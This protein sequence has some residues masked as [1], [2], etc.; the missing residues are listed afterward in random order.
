MSLLVISPDFA[1][2]YE[3]LAVLARAAQSDGR[4]VV[5]ATGPNIRQRAEAEG[6][7]W[8][9]LQLGAGSN[10]GVAGL[11]PGIERF[12]AASVRMICCGSL[13]G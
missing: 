3:P 9:S 13:S 10:T 7:E 6:F 1:S 4:R 8:R 12:I 11:D 5:V 2:H